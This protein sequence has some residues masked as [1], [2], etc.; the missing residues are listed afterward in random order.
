MIAGFQLHTRTSVTNKYNRYLLILLVVVYIIEEI[1]VYSYLCYY[2]E[3][4]VN[5]GEAHD[6]H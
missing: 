2:R 1:V 5:I 3:V 6:L 4:G